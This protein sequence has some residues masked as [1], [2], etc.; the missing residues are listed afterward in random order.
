MRVAIV[1]DM[2][3]DSDVVEWCKN[4]SYEQMLSKW[5]FAPSGDKF[6]TGDNGK[7]FAFIMKEKRAQITDAEHTQASKN[8][9]WG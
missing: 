1:T 5:R 2:N 3:P 9:G 7:Y 8:I 6:F 4:A